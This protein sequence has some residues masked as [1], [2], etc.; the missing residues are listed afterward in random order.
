MDEDLK[1]QMIDELNKIIESREPEVIEMY[2]K[3]RAAYLNHYD[4][5]ELDTLRHEVCLCLIFGLYQA[6]ITLTNHMLESLLKFALS[7]K[8]AFDNFK[9]N[10]EN[11]S[12]TTLLSSL[13][14]GFEH[15]DGKD[16]SY[17]INRSCTLGLITKDQKK[18]LHQFRQLFRNAYSHAEKKK[19]HGDKDIPVQSL[20]MTDRGKMDVDPEEV[21][22]ILDIPFIHGEAQYYHA[23]ANAPAYF[24]YVDALV[25]EIMPK[26]FKGMNLSDKDSA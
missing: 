21:H 15:Y 25:R 17:T 20:H 16:L 9:D 10:P 3:V 5:S 14:P 26:V 12:L 8:H 11:R 23:K 19:I 18:Q 7:Y 24:L 22:K 13:K 4:W 6:A 1:R 2:P